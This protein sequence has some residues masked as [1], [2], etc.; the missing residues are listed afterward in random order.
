MIIKNLINAD[1][2]FPI[3]A[4]PDQEGSKG[5]MSSWPPDERYQIPSLY[6]MYVK[7]VYTFF[8][9]KKTK[10]TKINSRVKIKIIRKTYHKKFQEQNLYK[11][12]VFF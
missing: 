10:I 6:K 8:T 12:R 7:V 4:D 9:E 1:I 3:T 2:Y 5:A 11:K